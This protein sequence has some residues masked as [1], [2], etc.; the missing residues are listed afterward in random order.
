M[1]KLV[2]LALALTL[3]F[4]SCGKADSG[5]DLL[6]IPEGTSV[7]LMD[8]FTYDVISYARDD[9]DIEDLLKKINE[10]EPDDITS[11]DFVDYKQDTP[12]FT[13]YVERETTYIFRTWSFGDGKC[14]ASLYMVGG[15]RNIYDITFTDTKI[16]S[17]I[18]KLYKSFEG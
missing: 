18:E 1:K 10:L 4:C 14:A 16:A 7:S 17:L 15:D 12:Y 11:V 13:V 3:L 6:T 8:P 9:D 5:F 2:L